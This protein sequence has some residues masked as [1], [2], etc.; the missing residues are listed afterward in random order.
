M[1]N[2]G[3]IVP[4]NNHLNNRDILNTM[5]QNYNSLCNHLDSIIRTSYEI[6]FGTITTAALVLTFAVFKGRSQP[7]FLFLLA[8]PPILFV[9]GLIYCHNFKSLLMYSSY[10]ITIEE[11]INEKFRIQEKEK[12]ILNISNELGIYSDKYRKY[13]FPTGLIMSIVFTSFYLFLT[14]ICY[15]TINLTTLDLSWLPLSDM[16]GFI[17]FFLYMGCGLILVM[18][19]LD[20][21]F[22]HTYNLKNLKKPQKFYIKKLDDNLKKLNKKIKNPRV[23][24]SIKWICKQIEKIMRGWEKI[25]NNRYRPKLDTYK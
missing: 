7:E 17:I 4:N 20:L 8:V 19:A 25:I 14:F 13:L 12:W 21:T 11:R 1:G 16:F 10:M 18:V 6:G 23:K 24:T 22:F 9:G 15:Y 2:N 3:G 5:L